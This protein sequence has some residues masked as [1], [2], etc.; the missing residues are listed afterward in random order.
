MVTGVQTCALSI[1]YMIEYFVPAGYEKVEAGILYGL[2]GTTP[3]VSSAYSK[4][5][6]SRTDKHGSLTAAP[7]GDSEAVVRGYL[8]YENASGEKR[9]IY[10]DVRTI[11]E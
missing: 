6:S 1:S 2:S 9:V 10:T 4:A 7:S 11:G 3:T 8:I 5:V